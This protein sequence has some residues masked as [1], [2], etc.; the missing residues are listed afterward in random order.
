MKKTATLLLA[1][2]I[3]FSFGQEL[4][5][6][7]SEN[8]KQIEGTNI[9]MVPPVSYQSSTNFKGFQNPDDQT[10]MIM[11]MEIPGPYLEV[12]KGFNT[13]MLKTKGMVLKNKNEIKV[14]EYTGLL[15]E[16][17]QLANGMEFS[18]HIIIYG[19]EKSTTLINGIFLKDSIEAGK[20]IKESILTTF[21]DSKL[22]TNPRENLDYSIN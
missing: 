1:L 14:G 8:H 16:I 4:P 9:F 18:K 11:A 6:Q 5:K 19:N 10:T 2:F 7:K 13:E 15:V 20:S 21:I 22:I 3:T 17:D 12:T